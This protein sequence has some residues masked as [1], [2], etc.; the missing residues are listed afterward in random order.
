[1]AY[2]AVGQLNLNFSYGWHPVSLAL[3]L[4][5][6]SVWLLLRRHRAWAAVV[7]LLAC[8]FK[9]SVL[10]T[11]ACLAAALA[12]Q[13]WLTRRQDT[14]S[15]GP[16]PSGGL[17]ATQLPA[18]GWAT[19]WAALSIAFALAYK[20]TSFSEFQTNRFSNLGHSAVEVLL[21]PVLRPSV[22][23]GQVLR[24]ESAW[25]VLSLLVPFGLPTVVRGWPVLLGVA[26]PIGVLLAWE[27]NAAPSIAFQYVT[28]CIPVFTV[29]AIAGTAA[30]AGANTRPLSP[31]S[32]RARCMFLVAGLSALTAGL[33]SS[34]FLGSLPWSR[35]TLTNMFANSYQTD[36]LSFLGNPRAV[37]TEGG[38][39]LDQIVAMVGHEDAAVLASGRVAAHLLGVRRLETVEQATVFR[40][41]ALCEEAGEGRSGVE[42]FDWIVL[43]TWEQVQQS[44]EKMQFVIREAERAG[45]HV[46]RSSHGVLV[47]AKPSGS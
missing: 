19:V 10:V 34:M 14:V 27:H 40:W 31:H 28:T 42:V 29:A 5:F 41:D 38:T 43:D 1:L 13:A 30:S 17:L 4:M 15:Q 24:Q 3:P 32:G 11:M 26:L 20:L 7:A 22:F 21:S 37:G 16:A 45:F 25:F 18:W 46:E 44:V 47:L 8:S 23:W 6:A 9:E 12:F 36:D 35:P 2:P 33:T 39:T